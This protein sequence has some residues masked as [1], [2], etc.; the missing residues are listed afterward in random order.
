VVLY[1]AKLIVLLEP[2]G[3]NKGSTCIK[4]EEAMPAYDSE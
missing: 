2:W 1:E 3:E 4:E